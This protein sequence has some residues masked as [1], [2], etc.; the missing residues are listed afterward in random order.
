MEI[1]A[2]PKQAVA[3][4]TN[5]DANRILPLYTKEMSL[6]DRIRGVLGF[7]VTP[8]RKDL[9]ID[10]DGLARN[11]DEMASHPFCALVAAGGTGE[12][13][14]MTPEEIE[15]VVKVTVEAVHGRMPVVAG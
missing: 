6:R 1:R 5:R 8:L 4:S 12:V 14:S 7:P 3:S 11:V 2:C 13:Y 9:S 15:R 10:L